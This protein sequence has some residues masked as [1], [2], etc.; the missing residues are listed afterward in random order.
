MSSFDNISEILHKGPFESEGIKLAKWKD[1][2]EES[3]LIC[4]ISDKEQKVYDFEYIG[5]LDN[6]LMRS[7]IGKYIYENQD[8]YLGEWKQNIKEGFGILLYQNNEFFSGKWRDNSMEDSGIYY[9]PRGSDDDF[10]CFIGRVE[11]NMHR[12]GLYISKRKPDFIHLESSLSSVYLYFGEFDKEGNKLD[13]YGFFYDF[14]KTFL[15]YGKILNN[16]AVEGK[17]IDYDPEK[18][19]FK[20]FLYFQ[21]DVV[22]HHISEITK[23]E[24]MDEE[25]IER[26]TTKC[27]KFIQYFVYQENLFDIVKKYKKNVNYLL[28]SSFYNQGKLEN[29]MFSKSQDKFLKAKTEFLGLYEKVE[30]FFTIIGD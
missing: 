26:L 8:R 5:F 4:I 19:S 21:T 29:D 16:R 12:R 20:D 18:N 3:Y 7:S 9:W 30:K 14:E 10:D 6:Q 11:Q 23:K 28:G 22:D 24:A 13:N 27:E 25:E 1:P 15:F 2:E 17:Q